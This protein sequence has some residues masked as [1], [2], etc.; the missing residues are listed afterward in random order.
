MS[1][2][3]F[4]S[5]DL[6]GDGTPG[7]LGCS[8]ATTGGWLGRSPLGVDVFEKSLDRAKALFVLCSTGGNP[9]FGAGDLDDEEMDPGVLSRTD[10]TIWTFLVGGSGIRSLIVGVLAEG[11]EW[12]EVVWHVLQ[13]HCHTRE[14]FEEPSAM[15]IPPGIYKFKST[16]AGRTE[17]CHI[18]SDEGRRVDPVYM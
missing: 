3:L 1:S 18:T 15:Y 2:R 17:S 7:S 10:P 11:G 16:S 9:V 8:E 5:S 12:I 13:E 14:S 6:S 4:D